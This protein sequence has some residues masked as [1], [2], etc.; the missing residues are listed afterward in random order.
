MIKGHGVD[1]I[2]VARVK[3][4]LNRF[5]ERFKTRIYTEAEIDYCMT[6]SNQVESFAARLAAKEAVYKVLSKELETLC[7]Q[8]ISVRWDG[9][10]P[11]IYLKGNARAAA[12]ELGIEAWH[13]SLS[14]ERDYAL[15]SVIAE[16]GR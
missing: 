10:L 11:V 12:K 2:K 15:A 8:E 16:G 13:L 5:D 4:I 1:I 14:H 3:R 9:C 6:A 7:W